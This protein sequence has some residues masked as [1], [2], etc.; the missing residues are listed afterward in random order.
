MALSYILLPKSLRVRSAL[1]RGLTLIE[2]MLTLAVLAI[3]MAIAAPSFTPM[4][5]R[6]QAN[7]AVDELES[8]LAFARS[9]SIRRGGGLSLLRI[10]QRGACKAADNEWQCGWTLAIDVDQDGSADNDQATLR[11]SSSSYNNLVISASANSDAIL[12]DRWG[13]LSLLDAGNIFVLSASPTDQPSAN[14]NK[15]C[16]QAGGLIRKT[17][18]LNAC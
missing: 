9:E 16:I 8:V 4:M 2:L 18:V 1:Q 3:L 10:A 14:T 5:E 15:L 13:T 6:W 7:Q 12:I 11:Q 17:S